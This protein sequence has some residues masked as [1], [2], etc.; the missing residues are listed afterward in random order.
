MTRLVKTSILALLVAPLACSTE[1]QL[2]RDLS[3]AQGGGDDVGG[4][5]P[6]PAP[7]CAGQDA[8]IKLPTAFCASTFADQVGRARQMTFSPSGDLYVAIADAHDGSEKG[9]VLALRDTNHDGRADQSERFGDHGGNGIAW[10]QGML[11]FAQNDQII[12]WALPDKQLVPEG[13]AEIV[14]CSLPVDGDH[15]AKTIVFGPHGEMYVNIGSATN[16]CQLENRALESPG[17]DPCDELRHRAGV[18]MF[19]TERLNQTQDDGVR[20]ATGLRNAN[21]LAVN[22]VTGGLWAAVN[23]RDQL[24][25]NWPD[26]Y[27]AEDDQRLPS[28]ELRQVNQGTNGGWP[29]CYHDPDLGMVLAPE[30]GGT[31]TEVGRCAEIREPD[32]AFPAHWAPLSMMFYTGTKFPPHYR[33]GAFVAFHGSR[34]APAAVTPPGYNVAFV[35][36]QNGQANPQWQVF[37]AGFAGEGRPLPDAAAHRP[38]GLAQAPDGSLFIS[39]DKG[40]RIY[41]VTFIA[42]TAPPVR[43]VPN[44]AIIGQ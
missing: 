18:W 11:Y 39:D 21:A 42:D 8:S 30:Y 13:E 31:G 2:G 38:V 23:G 15:I 6:L 12:R 33:N 17:D 3:P 9:Y 27:T 5:N 10:Y 29:Y 32:V 36:F 7:L 1:N 24:F 14:V 37:A 22:P 4:M 44:P 40:G 26:H 20:L 19:D 43:L 35:S 25:E 34:F 41:R 16:S 28:E